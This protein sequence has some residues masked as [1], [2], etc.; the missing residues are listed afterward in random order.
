MLL[1]SRPLYLETDELDGL[2]DIIMQLTRHI[3]AHALFGFQQPFSQMLIARQFLLQRL[4]KFTQPLDASAKNDPRV[5]LCLT[6]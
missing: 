5:I 3:T 1:S 6:R 4:V 2:T